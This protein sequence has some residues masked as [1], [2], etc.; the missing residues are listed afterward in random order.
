MAGGP[1]PS[2]AGCHDPAVSPPDLPGLQRSGRGLLLR[3]RHGNKLLD[4]P[5]M[6]HPA[7]DA[8]AG[9]AEC[10]AC[11]ALWSYNDQTTH[12]LLWLDDDVDPWERLAVQSM[13]AVESL[14]ENAMDFDADELPLAMPDGITRRAAAWRMV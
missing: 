2:C 9:Q 12:L 5:S 7:H 13:A 6:A 14:I 4:V 1:G 11:H 10:A 8:Y 3:T